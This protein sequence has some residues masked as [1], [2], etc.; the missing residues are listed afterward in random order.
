MR[1]H[2]TGLTLGKFAPL[3]RGHQ[4]MIETAMEETDEVIVVIYDC[5]DTIDIPLNVRANWIRT[6]YPQVQVIEAWDGPE[7]M[8]DTPEIKRMQEAYILKRL[9][10]KPITHFY[11][12]EFYGDHMSQA[13]GAVNRQVDPDRL[14]VP[15]SGTQV[16]DDP[17]ANRHFL[18]PVVYRDMIARF[19]FLGAPSTGK[20]TLAAHMAERHDTVWMPE[21]GREYWEKHQVNRRLTLRQLEDIA[22]GHLE[23]EEKLVQDARGMLFV[24]TNAITTYMFSLYYHGE[25][26]PLLAQRAVEAASRYD[27]VFVCDTDMPYDDTWDR[28]GEVQRHVFQK[29]IIADLQVRNIPYI[30]LSGSL[31]ERAEQASRMVAGF[32]KY[33]S[34]HYTGGLG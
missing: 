12:S 32:R 9:G 3:H 23:R 24:D 21:Y 1:Q 7:A 10:G 4:R 18:S 31:E 34:C 30:I 28:S 14:M 26:T 6:L 27:L 2:R 19:V 33:R 8:G 5:P 17:Y 29:Q 13:L 25:A 20:T 11:S 16:R 15:V 22:E